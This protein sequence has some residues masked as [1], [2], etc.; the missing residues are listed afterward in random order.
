MEQRMKNLIRSGSSRRDFLKTSLMSSAALC[1]GGCAEKKSLSLA[2]APGLASPPALT[3]FKVN[4]I[5]SQLNSALVSE[6]LTPTS[7]DQCRDILRAAR[8]A[9]KAVAVSG[10]RHS[11]GGQQFADGSALIDT[12]SLKRVLSF[13]R[14][15]GLLDVEAGIEWP[16]LI[17]YL[18]TEQEGQEKQWA[19]VQKQ[20]GADKFTLGGSLAS[21]VHGRVLQD[22]PIIANVESF[23]LLDSDGELRECSRQS[24][25]DL[26]RLAIGGYGMFGLI[27]SVK[28]RL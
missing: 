25:P 2:S 20:T 26:F 11:M 21:N 13:D 16:E 6:V 19:I 23:T 17:E 27:T 12:R 10:G 14:E 22:K 18:H 1:L 24:N 3:G 4:D 8:Q 15:R 7:I 28:L 9:N 5:H